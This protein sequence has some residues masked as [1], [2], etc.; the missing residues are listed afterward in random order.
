MKTSNALAVSVI[1]GLFWAQ[2]AMA[3]GPT[4]PCDT[5][6]TL[7][8]TKKATPECSGGDCTKLVA[9]STIGKE[10]TKKK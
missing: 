1:G 10:P 4:M 8:L 2:V 5:G 3:G 7:H 9:A 6:G